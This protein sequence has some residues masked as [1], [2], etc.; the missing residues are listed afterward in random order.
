[1]KG[2]IAR[3]VL[4]DAGFWLGLLDTR[5]AHHASAREVYKRIE[6]WYGLFPWPVLY[7]VASTRLARDEQKMLRLGHELRS[8]GVIKVPDERYRERV[9]DH[10]TTETERP[11]GSVRCNL[12][13]VDA[14]L[15]SMLA[16]RN[17]RV[18][19]FVTFNPRDFHDVCHSRGIEV[20]AGAVSSP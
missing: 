7:E 14:V 8:P 9:L 15:R 1:M 17:L 12:S 2:S 13:L 4:C 3:Y 11:R 16:D 10:V 19:H 5:D 6:P 18:H 20:I